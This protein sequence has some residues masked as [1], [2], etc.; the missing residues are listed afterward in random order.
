MSRRITT[1]FNVLKVMEWILFFGL[2]GLSAVFMWE[3]WDKF[4]SGKSSFTQSEEPINELPTITMCFSFNGKFDGYS[5]YQYT[6]DF[7]IFYHVDVGTPFGFL[8]LGKNVNP[9][10]TIDLRKII[11]GYSGTCYKVSSIPH[12]IPKRKY[13]SLILYFNM[14]IPHEKLPYVKFYITSE[15]NAYG[16]LEQ[17]WWDGKVKITVV[18]KNYWKQVNLKPQQYNYLKTNSKCREESFFECFENIFAYNLNECP[19]I[20]SPV[21]LPT[22]PY[23]ETDLEYQ[24]VSDIYQYTYYYLKQQNNTDALCPKACTFLDYPGEETWSTKL[25]NFYGT[26]EN[27]NVTHGFSY[28]FDPPESVS[29]YEEYLIYDEITLIGSV[30][31]T[32]G[33]C[34]GFSFTNVITVVINFVRNLKS[35]M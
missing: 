13:T 7:K 8:K 27:Y 33:L 25:S 29:V 28:Q 17:V 26:K 4:I 15:K 14:S 32:L 5:D 30:G 31:G 9:F 23:C 34:I 20:C 1:D 3:G 21:S 18:E 12:S 22:M 6:L 35:A 19:K 16:I 2:C 11:T 10:E 24:C